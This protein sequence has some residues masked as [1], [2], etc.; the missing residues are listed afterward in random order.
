MQQD[1][2]A[3][4]ADMRSIVYTCEIASGQPFSEA[5]VQVPKM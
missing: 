4:G 2:N 3:Q 5:P 1:G